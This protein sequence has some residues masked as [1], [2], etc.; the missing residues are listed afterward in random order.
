MSNVLIQP[1]PSFDEPLEMLA[2]CHGRMLGQLDTLRRLA[3][4][5]PEHGADAEAR[6]AARSILHFF[7]T[8]AR[9]HHEDEEVDVFPRLLERVDAVD[10]R[11]AE[12]LVTSLLADHQELYAAWDVVRNHLEAIEAGTGDC[13]PDRDVRYFTQQ[14]RN[15]VHCEEAML[16][17]LLVRY[18]DVQDLMQLGSRMG[19]RRKAG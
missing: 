8:A 13:L 19:G 6:R 5:L 2:A 9:H 14:Y 15:H 10:R 1:A 12:R 17:P 3:G 11:Q 4:W 7:R 18:F 16:F